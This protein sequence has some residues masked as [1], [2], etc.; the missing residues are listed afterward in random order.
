MERESATTNAVSNVGTKSKDGHKPMPNLGS[1]A[2]QSANGEEAPATNGKAQ[3]WRIILPL[4][5]FLLVVLS[6][7]VCARVSRKRR[8]HGIRQPEN[9]CVQA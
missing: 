1:N 2:E 8:D 6:V 7:A 9:K 4:L 3:Y 5:T